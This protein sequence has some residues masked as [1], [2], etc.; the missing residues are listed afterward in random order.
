MRKYWW[1]QKPKEQKQI[2]KYNSNKKYDVI[3]HILEDH[4]KSEP[5]EDSKLRT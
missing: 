1:Q 4:T 5:M 3:T 2:R